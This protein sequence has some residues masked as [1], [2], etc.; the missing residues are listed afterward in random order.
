MQANVPDI[1]PGVPKAKNK[2]KYCL[3]SFFRY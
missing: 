1:R 3:A 2:V